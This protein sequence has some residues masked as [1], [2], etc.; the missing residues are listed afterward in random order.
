M[1]EKQ[2]T[3]SAVRE[4][5]KEASEEAKEASDEV[6]ELSDPIAVDIEAR[7]CAVATSEVGDATLGSR[8]AVAEEPPSRK[9]SDRVV[10]PDVEGVDIRMELKV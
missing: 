1:A 6:K 7:S 8:T 9:G 3:E 5:A 10:I 2:S 4:D